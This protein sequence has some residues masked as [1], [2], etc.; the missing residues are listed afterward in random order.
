MAESPLMSERGLA[1]SESQRVI[2]FG[3]MFSLPVML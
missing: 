1:A 3:F 2:L